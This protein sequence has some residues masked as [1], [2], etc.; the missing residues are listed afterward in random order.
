MESFPIE[1]KTFAAVKTIKKS[2]EIATYSPFIGPA[3]IIRSTGRIVR[4]VI[5]SLILSTQFYSTPDKP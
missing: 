1:L 2:S 4:L 5:M 3:G